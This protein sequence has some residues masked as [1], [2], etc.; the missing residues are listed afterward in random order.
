MIT[1]PYQILK[2]RL[3]TDVPELREV[4]FYTGQDSTT[5]KTASLRAAPGVYITFL[6]ANTESLSGQKI[7]SGITQFEA[8]LLTECLLDGDK[9][10][11]TDHALDHMVLFDK[12]FKS[13]QNFRAKLS[14]LPA[15]LALKGTVNDQNVINSIDRI[16]IPVQPHIARK[17]MMK[18]VQR[19]S[20]VMYDHAGAGLY[21]KIT[22]K[23]PLEITTDIALPL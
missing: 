1:Y 15:F 9:R 22:P 2:L 19:F 8:M 21:T 10:I 6:P 3:Q 17:A 7:Q 14:Y 13:L 18:S 11:K 20:A 4:E 12:I 16:G 5:D 23:P